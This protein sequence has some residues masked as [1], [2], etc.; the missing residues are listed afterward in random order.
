MKKSKIVIFTLLCAILGLS[1]TGCGRANGSVASKREAI[2]YVK[3]NISED[4]TFVKEEQVSESPR[5]VVYTFKSDARGF[6][7]KVVAQRWPHGWYEAVFYY[8][9]IITEYY[10]IGL[11]HYYDERM[12]EVF[13]DLLDHKSMYLYI[14]S[15]E[16]IEKLSKAIVEA[17]AIYAEEKEYNTDTFLKENPYC[18]GN[19]RVKSGDSSWSVAAIPIDGSK[20]TEEAIKEKLLKAVSQY[21]KDGKLSADDFPGVDSYTKN[22]HVTTLKNMYINGEKIEA[23]SS[24]DWNRQEKY[25][26]AEYDKDRQTYMMY[27]DEGFVV[28]RGARKPFCITTVVNALGGEFS[29][30]SQSYDDYPAD[31]KAEWTING[32]V[33]NASVHFDRPNNGLDYSDLQVTRDGIAL[34]IEYTY[35]STSLYFTPIRIDDF[36][37]LFD[38]TY[39]INEEESSVYFTS[40]Q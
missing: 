21:V 27:I 19:V 7:F 12:Y 33:W 16:D 13:G 38:L 29:S 6:E 26:F 40:I 5:K 23:Y 24:E 11:H 3:K 22:L 4:C 17:N 34:N 15:T 35:G 31:L 2:N 36:C 8:E 20:Y 14:S 32:H 10:D 18:R 37:S 30:P 39:E 1:I 9:P 28:S 25:C